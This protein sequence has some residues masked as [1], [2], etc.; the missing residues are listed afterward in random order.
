MGRI[1]PTSVAGALL[2]G[3]CKMFADFCIGEAIIR[4]SAL[5]V[6]LLLAVIGTAIE[7]G[8]LLGTVESSGFLIIV[9]LAAANKNIEPAIKRLDRFIAAR[10]ARVRT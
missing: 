1:E 6:G 8:V 2:N 10:V 5:T 4:G 3:V 9:Q 7:A